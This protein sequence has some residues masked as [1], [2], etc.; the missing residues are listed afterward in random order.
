MDKFS[1][2]IDSLSKIS[3]ARTG[4]ITTPNGIINTPAFIFCATKAALKS[5]TTTDAKKIGT[6]IIL[7]NTYHLMLQPGS[8]LIAD[9]GGLHK[10]MNWSGPMLTDSGGFQIFSL[11]HGSVSD[12]IKGRHIESKKNKS[13]LK[14]NEEGALFKSYLDGKNLLL[15]PEKSIQIQRDLGAD[16]ILVFDECTPFNVDKKYTEKSMQRSHRWAQRS[17]NSFN[18]S[19]NYSPKYGSSGEQRLYGIIQGGV[20]EDLREES[21]EFNLNQIDVFGIAIGGSLGSTKEEMYNVVNFTGRKLGVNHPIHLLGIGD[22]KDIW[23]LVKA[24]IDTFDCVSPTRLARHGGALMKNETGKINIYNKQYENK[25]S[26][27][28]KNCL[29]ETCQNFSLSYLHH[30]F[31]TNEL[32]GFQLLTLHNIFFMNEL[33]NIIR[34]AI[35]KDRLEEAEN[36]WYYKK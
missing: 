13:L 16:L 36:E 1:W 8:K 26:P 12:E 23:S 24:G 25:N 17:L 35:K 7:S 31:K 14:I 15:S 30:L 6:Q 21:I 5:I 2:K 19:L 4:Y 3:K 34:A 20:Y 32:L 33:M 9:H 10:F 18:S 22:P 11:G 28:D 27:I 29:C